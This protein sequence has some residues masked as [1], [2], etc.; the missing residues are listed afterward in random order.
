M[1][2]EHTFVDEARLTV[3]SGDGGNGMASFRRE[4]FVPNGGPNGGDG[5]RGGD[6][7]LIADRNRNTLSEFHYRQKM[8]AKNGAGGGTSG[9]TGADGADLVIELPV[10]TVVYD[11]DAPE[12]AAPIVDL[13]E[14]GQR[15]VIARGGKGG[16]GNIHF[17][18][19]RRQAPDFALPGLPGESV[20]LRLSLKLL[21]DV[22]LVGFPNAGKSTLLGR[23]SEARPRVAAYPFTTLTPSLGVVERGDDRLVVADIPGLI[24][25][26]ADGTGLGHRFLRHVERT[27]VLVHLLDLGAMLLEERDLLHDY[28]TLRAELGRYDARLLERPEIVVLSK[29]DLADEASLETARKALA[30]RGLEPTVLSAATGDGVDE[31][32][33]R[34]FETVARARR[35]G[36]VSNAAPSA[37]PETISS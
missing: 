18:S 4:K 32:V 14:D 11:A 5:G 3:R 25:G 23:V 12:D 34:I 7:V 29:A 8:S 33:G 13:S 1:K 21:A 22:G 30:T 16:L 9:K 17:K 26:A 37:A 35:E 24:E 20:S 15:F 36:E 31:L 27:R 19:S 28:D 2:S 10:G 6:V